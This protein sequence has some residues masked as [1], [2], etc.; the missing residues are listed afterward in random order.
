MSQPLPIPTRSSQAKFYDPRTDPRKWWIPNPPELEPSSAAYLCDRCRHIDFEY[1]ILK[2]EFGQ[3]L[4]EIPLDRLNLVLA[5]QQCAFCRLV[6]QTLE[7]YYGTQAIRQ[8]GEDDSFVASMIAIFRSPWTCSTEPWNLKIWIKPT[9]QG[10]DPN[11]SLLIHQVDDEDWLEAGTS[12]RGVLLSPEANLAKA[13]LWISVCQTGFGLCK[14][15]SK[16]EERPVSSKGFRLIDVEKKCIVP[17]DYSYEYFALSYVWGSS[18]CLKITRENEHLFAIEDSLTHHSGLIPQTILDAMELTSN[19]RQRY[20]WVDALC[21]LQDDPQVLQSQIAA[22]KTIY[23]Q[24]ALMIAAAYGKDANAGLSRLRRGKHTAETT[25]EKI[26]GIGLA[27]K[28]QG[29]DDAVNQSVWNTRAWTYQERLLSPR[30]LFFTEQQMFFKCEHC[31]EPRSEDTAAFGTKRYTSPNPTSDGGSDLL[32]RQH[33]INT[34]SYK[35]VVEEYTRRNLTRPEDV[36]DAFAGVAEHLK[37]LF[38]SQLLYGLPETEL[39]FALLWKPHGPFTRRTGKSDLNPNLALFPSWSWTGWEGQVKYNCGDLLVRVE[40]VL[41]NGEIT[42]LDELRH[43]VLEDSPS[44]DLL[45]WRDSWTEH[46]SDDSRPRA[47]YYQQAVN[48]N[49]WFAHPVAPLENRTCPS[50][51]LTSTTSHGDRVLKFWAETVKL[52]IPSDFRPPANF[53]DPHWW[54]SL[55]GKD[56]LGHVGGA[57]YIPSSY[58][59]SLA[60]KKLD[61]VMMARQRSN[62]EPKHN[63]WEETLKQEILRSRTKTSRSDR[64][65]P[66]QDMGYES[67]RSLVRDYFPDRPQITQNKPDIDAQRFD[68]HKPFCLCQLLLVEWMDSG[69]AERIGHATVHMDFWVQEKP[70]VKLVTLV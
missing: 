12:G 56:G 27:P 35:Q 43:P 66:L 22:M 11:P 64:Y 61:L 14:Y 16:N 17:A 34:V 37:H 54:L 8:F 57:M 47:Y 51:L 41:E 19:F 67:D 9:P 55:S 4:E 58:L 69:V 32:P 31:E 70:V 36:I 24:S 29:F 50:T 6:K 30:V 68:M 48:P 52:E 21:I 13:K 20:L 49:I 40:F 39:V 28:P 45:W 42:T 1:L 18:A 15:Q 59:A 33:S 23:S 38:R 53:A 63:G 25:V 7:L 60:G 3:V 62:A 2:S 46:I 44:T 26:Q 5:R 10:T 65:A